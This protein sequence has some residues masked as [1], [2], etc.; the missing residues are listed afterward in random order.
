MLNFLFQG[1]FDLLSGV[2]ERFFDLIM[3]AFAIGSG[4]FEAMFPVLTDI[5]SAFVAVGCPS[6]VWS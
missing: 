1:L 5:R 3:E 4:D 6:K 2:V